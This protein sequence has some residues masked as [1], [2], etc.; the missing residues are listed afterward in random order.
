MPIATAARP[1]PAGSSEA[2]PVVRVSAAAPS[3]RDR[4]EELAR[5]AP[6]LLQ[7]VVRRL[8]LPAP[9]RID[10]V[11]A[12]GLPSNPEALRRAG[13]PRSPGWAAGIADAR[14]Q[15][16]VLFSDRIQT[17]PHDAIEGVLTH[18]LAHLVLSHALPAERRLPRWYEEGVAMIVERQSSIEDALQLARLT[19]LEE[20]WPLTRLERGW[21]TS[22]PQAR[23]AYA[24]ALSIVDLAE[25]RAAPG[26]I[27]RL[28]DAMRRGNSFED[29][30]VAAY[31][32]SVREHEARWRRS[33]RLHYLYVPVAVL[34]TLANGSMG[35]LALVA[36]FKVRRRRRDQLEA[37]ER[38][39]SG[40]GGGEEPDRWTH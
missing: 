19:I 38:E 29:A 34:G 1:D 12:P 22:A 6:A 3:E 31:G 33:L 24:Q 11:V 35:L 23:R 32:R 26:S 25:R 14:R 28:V 9:P 4:A 18:E 36:Y 37:M 2:A 27:R 8:E 10:V 13:L 39:E 5:R 20:P 30:F 15:R 40:W 16:I 17:Y 21:P 7:G